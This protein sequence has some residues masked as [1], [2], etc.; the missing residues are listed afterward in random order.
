MLPKLAFVL[1]GA[2]S[3]KSDVAERLV[4]SW[5]ETRVY[6]AT[7]RAFDD[8]MARKIAAHRESRATHGWRTVEAPVELARAVGDLPAGAVALIDCATLWLS[9]LLLEEAE[10]GPAI[11]AL[12]DALAA[13]P[14]PV[15][16]VSN[17]VGA[18]VVPE[19][20]LGR[21]FRTAQG[22]LNR[23]LATRAD[24]VIGVMA[25]LP[26]ALKGALPGALA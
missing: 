6:V 3:G 21:Q 10:I 26:F 20:P 8:E 16:V 2:A 11:E 19:T 14:C 25:G 5:G 7:A 1:G 12:C 15:A 9:N 13:A 23:Q 22:A 4:R 18:G 24:P 17:E